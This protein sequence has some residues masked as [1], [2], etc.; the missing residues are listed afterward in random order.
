MADV[1]SGTNLKAI[2]LFVNRSSLNGRAFRLPD[3]DAIFQEVSLGCL[4]ERFTALMLIRYC[5][6]GSRHSDMLFNE[7]SEARFTAQRYKT[8]SD[9]LVPASKYMMTQIIMLV[10]LDNTPD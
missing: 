8:T 3:M 7:F 4:V 5:Y 9:N 2:R 10:R 6:T 1:N